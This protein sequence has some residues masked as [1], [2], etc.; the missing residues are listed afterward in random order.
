LRRPPRPPALHCRGCLTAPQRRIA[1]DTASK[2][3]DLRQHQE[4]QRAPHAPQAW[5]RVL[6]FSGAVSAVLGADAPRAGEP[7]PDELQIA[8]ERALWELLAMFSLDGAG[9][10]RAWGQELAGW[11]ARNAVGVAGGAA[12]APLPPALWAQLQA[13]ALPEAHPQYWPALQRLVATGQVRAGLE[14]LGLHSAWLRWGGAGAPGGGADGQAGALEPVA[15]LLKRFPAL[16][17]GQAAAEAGGREFDT[18]HE[19]LTYRRGWQAQCAAVLRDGALW[20]RCEAEAPDTAAG[21]RR[22]VAALAGEDAALVAAARGWAELLAARL[23]HRHP[24]ASSPA[25]LRQLAERCAQDAAGVGTPAGEELSG[26]LAAA[27]DACC[28]ADAQSAMRAASAFAS[29]WFMAHVP[30]V[31]GGAPG[32]ARE[33]G[34]ELPHA[35]GSQVEFYALEYA[36]ALAPHA[37]T[38][39]LAAAYLAWCPAHGR[40]ALEAVVA[41]LPLEAADARG[42]LRAVELCEAQ[43]LGRAATGEAALALRRRS[44]AVPGQPAPHRSTHHAQRSRRRLHVSF[45][46]SVQAC[47]GR[48]AWRAGRRA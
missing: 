16:R 35:G 39:P 10:E 27:L 28:D 38:R 11:L 9:V 32:G 23:L 13:D 29:D 20:A 42:A 15:L 33:L 36:A 37:A 2:Y 24:A 22:V 7:S 30:A 46:F 48:R 44:R 47:A 31:L 43:G 5:A 41:A 1:Y 21:L 34:R 19:C 17:R 40:G 14:L 4:A 6:E 18:L 3:I 12:A 26:A 45:V 25:E 8:Q